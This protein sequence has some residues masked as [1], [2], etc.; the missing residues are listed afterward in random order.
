MPEVLTGTDKDGA[1]LRFE[2]NTDNVGVDLSSI[3]G[4]LAESAPSVQEHV[5]AAHAEK[6]ASAPVDS[7]N[8]P[9]D[10]AI[11]SSDSEGKGI[12]TQAGKWRRKRGKGSASNAAKT[13]TL[14]QSEASS[15]PSAAQQAATATGIACAEMTIGT[16]TMVFGPEWQARVHK[17]ETGR[18]LL[19]ERSYMAKAYADYCAAKGIHDI[20]PGVALSLAL[21]AYA[22]PRFAEPET[23]E[24]A[25]TIREWLACKVASWKV[26]KEL[27]KRGIVGASVK[28]HRVGQP[29]RGGK[30]QIL[31]NGEAWKG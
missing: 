18:V 27:R 12:K 19:D 20:P 26:K 8:Q 13:S 10:P 5:I 25:G 9:F 17:D 31:V 7:D 24:R 29:V 2:I 14:G 22:A 11:H 23:R 1:P 28:V 15:G 4:Q 6:Q 16:C 3:A 21:V 30:F